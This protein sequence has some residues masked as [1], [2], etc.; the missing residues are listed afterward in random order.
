MNAD[1]RRFVSALLKR[2]AAR[3]SLPLIRHPRSSAFI[4]GC[5]FLFGGLARA[6]TLRFRP[7]EIA[8]DLKVGYAVSLVDMNDDRKTDIVVVDSNRVIWY[9]NPSWAVHTI[10]KD[11]TRLDNVCIAPY[12]IDGDG[13]LDFALG[14]AWQPSNTSSGGTIQWLARGKSP[15]DLWEVRTIAEEPT[16]HRMRWMDTDD[17]GRQELI[18]VP[19]FGRDTTKPNFQERGIR[20]LAFKIPRD[21]V[22]DR[23]PV[24]SLNE[25]LHVAHNFWPTDLDGDKRL[26]MLV[27]SFEGVSVLKRG[28]DGRWPATRIGE[29]NQ[30]TT[31]NR[32]ASE[33]K[34]GHVASGADYVATIEPWHG[35]QV[36]TYTRPAK[37]EKQT[38]WTRQVV[39]EDLKWGHAVWCANLDADADEELIIGV[40]DNKDEKSLCGFRI[41]DPKD[42]Q[43]TAWERHLFDAGGVSIEDLAAADLNG[44][45]KTDVVAVGRFTHNVRIYWNETK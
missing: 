28:A 25:D 44:D 1:E 4:C 32:G 33:V 40:R 23:W 2:L 43:A 8:T 38:L 24:E 37:G 36:V 10:I 9:E 5:L 41:Y 11:Q 18:V 35:H 19:L 45:G 3:T 12:D 6:D 22:R 7:Q 26:D 20:V 16:T 17:D 34:H 39:D 29:G 42:G 31:P 21:P 14:A 27:T 15:A 13:K 30:A